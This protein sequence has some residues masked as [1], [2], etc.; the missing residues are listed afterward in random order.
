MKKTELTMLKLVTFNRP[1]NSAIMTLNVCDL[2][3]QAGIM[4]GAVVA[5][6]ETPNDDSCRI[7][8]VLLSIC[9]TDAAEVSIT[10]PIF[11]SLA[12]ADEVV[13]LSTAFG[14]KMSVAFLDFSKTTNDTSVA[15]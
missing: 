14:G 9:A 8:K 13:L 7:D 12:N 6:S 2:A 15:P 3:F 1:P 11:Q 10:L 5:P 4:K